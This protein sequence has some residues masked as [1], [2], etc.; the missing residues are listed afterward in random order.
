MDQLKKWVA[1]TAVASVLVLAAGWFL[2]VSPKRSEAAE[3]RDQAAV[4]TQANE[5]AATQLEVLRAQAKD[6]PKEQAKLAAVAAKIP[7]DPALPSLVRALLGAAESSG[8]ELVSVAPGV[9]ELVAAP[10]PAPAEAPATGQTTPPASDPAAGAGAAPAAGAVPAPIGPAGQLATIDVALNVAG[11]FFEVQRFVALLEELPRA[12]KVS[13]LVITP[14]LPP[15]E[16]DQSRSTEDGRSLTTLIT[17]QVFMA[18]DRPVPSA[19]TVPG[20]AATADAPA[21]AAATTAT[22][23]G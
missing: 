12:L 10:A 6:L 17:G 1:M 8:V 23:A 11:D 13:D 21:D 4:Q 20:G 5:K 14:G 7:A 2:A 22:P 15:T 16:K 18:A 3:L 9:P 19:V